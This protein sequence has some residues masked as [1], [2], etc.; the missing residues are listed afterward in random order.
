MNCFCSRYIFNLVHQLKVHYFVALSCL[1]CLLAISHRGEEP[2]RCCFHYYPHRFAIGVYDVKID[3]SAENVNRLTEY[4]QLV[5]MGSYN[6]TATTD[7][8]SPNL[9]SRENIKY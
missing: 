5:T 3:F 8:Y 7:V 4:L 6:L 2:C 1:S 9:L